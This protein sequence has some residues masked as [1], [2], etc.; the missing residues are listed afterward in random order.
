MGRMPEPQQGFAIGV[1][2]GTSNTVAVIRWPDGRTRPLLI[3]GAPIMPSGVFADDSGQLLVG[4]DAQRLAGLDPSRFEPNPK[5]RIDEPLVLLGNREVASV[6]LLAALLAS[7]ARSAV[8][9]VGF[10]P[11]AV[12]TH[13]AAWG[14]QR[15]TILA[16]AAQRAGWPPVHLIPEPVAAARYFADI[17]RRPVPVGSALAVFDFGGGTLDIAVVR[18]E[19]GHFTVLGSGGIEN[20]GGL[21]VDAALV[22]H[23]GGVL[24]HTAPDVWRTI[25]H[26]DS[27]TQRR[28]RR[29]FWE[30]VR[31]A[32]EMLSRTAVAPI[33]TPGRDQ[34]IHLTREELER[35]AEPLLRRAVWETAEVI[36]RC[37]LRP[38]QLAGLFLVGGSSRLP[39]VARLLHMELGI[40]PTVLEQPE[41]PV[42]EGALAELA[43]V[44]PLT[45]AGM[46][47][48]SAPP[49]SPAAPVAPPPAAAP[50]PTPAPA[51]ALPAPGLPFYKRPIAWIAAGVAVVLVV[52]LG[53][54]YAFRRL[55]GSDNPVDFATL[56]AGPSYALG[57]ERSM[58]YAYT[59][60]LGERAYYGW[61]ENKKFKIGSVDVAT[62]KPYWGP[63]EIDLD[64][65]KWSLVA[66]PGK[67]VVLGLGSGEPGAVYVFDESGKESFHIP[68]E[69][70]DHLY[71]F[72]DQLVLH[73][74]KAK[75]LR[76]LDWK[77]GETK[78]T[79][80]NPK[81][82][83]SQ[84]AYSVG[85]GVKA[86][87]HG[88]AGYYG[89]SFVP[90]LDNGSSRVLV[91][92]NADKKLHLIDVTTHKEVSSWAF[93]DKDSY[94]KA[95]AFGG[96]FYSTFGSPYRMEAYDLD[97][98]SQQPQVVYTAK[99]AKRYA[100]VMSAC[101]EGR[102]CVLDSATSSTDETTQVA[103]IDVA[104]Q[105]ELW[106]K[107]AP[108]MQYLT[109]VGSN[110]LATRIDGPQGS[111]LFGDTGKQVLSAD[112][113][114]AYAVRVN[115]A[116]LLVFSGD[117]ETGSTSNESL[118]GVSA[119]D[120]KRT[121]LGPLDKI[122]AP[123][124]SWTQTDIL[125]VTGG[126]LQ[127]WK[128]AA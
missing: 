20:L 82:E 72:K 9:A 112:D 15:R 81:T 57:D 121:S 53:G 58:Y 34:A 71:L 3:D 24:D 105:K 45:S 109:Q 103:M 42:A 80:D 17:L 63:V 89:Q 69:R 6:D 14:P 83:Y 31:G 75:Q 30:D 116:S 107:P 12:L 5:R 25:T 26:P 11:E 21:D 18:R 78:W 125:C 76:G 19:N 92:S 33:A 94:S 50:A 127:F 74:D 120:G 79:I 106:R 77:H 10:L 88:P 90:D 113:Q 119:A 95:Y 1:D 123:S 67:L 49:V 118:I 37:G 114:K 73:S 124:C 47:V 59:A 52:A 54:L 104:A 111:L 108:K 97:K 13:P 68:Y 101:G 8:E 28:D 35:V 122:L 39:M 98:P 16:M 7:V 56:R 115:S 38:D 110:V 96:K 70:D 27:T 40:A 128:F 46:P 43:P 48:T 29:L 117:L 23:L 99:D 60:V 93:E 2:L 65:S 62:G 44:A 102:I 4:R 55:N 91:V 86:D 100:L 41:L 66:L 84:E 87:Q 36:R 61:V 22:D 126:K 32:K 64:T 51:P 85:E